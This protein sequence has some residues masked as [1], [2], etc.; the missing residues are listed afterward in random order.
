MPKTFEQAR[1][2]NELVPGSPGA[3]QTQITGAEVVG[4]WL[5]G[6][7]DAGWTFT[8]LKEWVKLDADWMSKSVYDSNGDGR[9]DEALNL[10]D[11]TNIVSAVEARNHID[12]T[13]IHFVI[14]DTSTTTTVAWSGLKI[15]SEISGLTSIINTKENSLGNPASDGQQL[16]STAAGARS[17]EDEKVV[18]TGGSEG[19]I[20]VKQ[21]ATEQDALWQDIPLAFSSSWAFDSATAD[22]DPGTGQFRLNAATQATTTALYIN[23]TNSNGINLKE[24]L[25]SA[26]VGMRFVVYEQQDSNRGALY[27]IT[28][29]MVDKTTY[30][31]LAVAFVDQGTGE[32]RNGR[33]CHFEFFGFSGDTDLSNAV[34]PDWAGFENEGSTAIVVSGNTNINF[35]ASN[36]H[37]LTGTGSTTINTLTFPTP[38]AH[39]S[40][41]IP[42]TITIAGVTA[43]SKQEYGTNNFTAGKAHIMSIYWDGTTAHWQTS[44]AP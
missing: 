3:Q 25:E 17:W 22:A 28:A 44:E 34:F 10:S 33:I 21:S 30:G 35:S 5:T 18:P 41:V 15:N 29:K 38:H 26:P 2:E 11:G 31:D 23:Y 24:I 16:V 39:Y 43:T 4:A 6:A 8:N 27:R 1:A 19:Q 7:V 13:A 14:N 36:K 20:I 42:S 12:N 37:A 40:V 32:F 9:V